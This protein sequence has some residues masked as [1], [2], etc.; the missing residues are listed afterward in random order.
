MLSC[1]Q[2]N[3]HLRQSH[4][5]KMTWWKAFYSPFSLF[6]QSKQII[7]D[8]LW[9]SQRKVTRC[10]VTNRM[11]N[12]QI[13]KLILLAEFYYKNWLVILFTRLGDSYMC[14]FS[15]LTCRYLDNWLI[16]H[17]HH[18]HHSNLNVKN[19]IYIYIYLAEA[20]GKVPDNK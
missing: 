20:K 18:C 9:H 17:I 16:H 6:G 12:L 5:P 3:F 11:P 2:A 4:V 19:I 7:S 14:N 1:C 15:Y 8:K 10:I 13:R